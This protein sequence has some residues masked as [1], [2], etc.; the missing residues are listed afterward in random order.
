VQKIALQTHQLVSDSASPT[1]S[2]VSAAR[3]SASR[4]KTSA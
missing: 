2:I 4:A 1:S 3:L